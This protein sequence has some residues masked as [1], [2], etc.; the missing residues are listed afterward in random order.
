MGDLTSP[1]RVDIGWVFVIVR[2]MDGICLDVIPDFAHADR[3]EMAW[4]L[5]I[6]L[7]HFARYDIYSLIQF[8]NCWCEKPE[9]NSSPFL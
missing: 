1:L 2:P 5:G 6:I 7:C 3:I 8:K 4:P 9:R